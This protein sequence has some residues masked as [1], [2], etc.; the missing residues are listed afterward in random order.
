ML[1]PGSGREK[2]GASMIN[3]VSLPYPKPSK[4]T[5]KKELLYIGLQCSVNTFSNQYAFIVPQFTV[6]IGLG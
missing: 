3:A 6:L 4:G 1:V 2:E 5:A